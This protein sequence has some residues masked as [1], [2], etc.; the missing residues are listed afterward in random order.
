MKKQKWIELAAG[1][2]ELTLELGFDALLIVGL[3]VFVYGLSL[4]WRPLGFIAGGLLLSAFAFLIGYKR[5][6]RQSQP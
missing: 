1:A 2:L 4:A 6:A 5:T 3:V